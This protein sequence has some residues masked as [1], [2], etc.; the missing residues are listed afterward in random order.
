LGE[1]HL[2]YEKREDDL[3]FFLSDHVR[4]SIKYNSPTKV[5][6]QMWRLDTLLA[7]DVGNM[8]AASFRKRLARDGTNSTFHSN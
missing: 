5:I 2:E 4:V 6:V 8:N 3:L 7:P 1:R